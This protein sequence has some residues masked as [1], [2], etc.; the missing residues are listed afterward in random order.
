MCTVRYSIKQ[1]EENYFREQLMLYRPWRN[2]QNQM[3]N[4]HTFKEQ[5]QN[6]SED[7]SNQKASYEKIDILS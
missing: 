1:N 7:I 2:E 3:R 5:F 6:H 4:S